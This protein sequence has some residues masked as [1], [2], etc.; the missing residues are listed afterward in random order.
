[1]KH[2]HRHS[3]LSMHGKP[4]ERTKA[5]YEDLVSQCQRQGLV[6]SVCPLRRA[7]GLSGYL[8]S[9]RPGTPGTALWTSEAAVR[10]LRWLGFKSGSRGVTCG[11]LG[12]IPSCQKYLG[13]RGNLN[14]NQYRGK[15]LNTKQ[16]GCNSMLVTKTADGWRQT[17]GIH[18]RLARGTIFV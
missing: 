18:T 13:E 14:R 8:A 6:H 2:D 4:A 11:T 7:S 10:V 5:K 15:S 3:K 17:R 12:H 16:A 9:S 1:M